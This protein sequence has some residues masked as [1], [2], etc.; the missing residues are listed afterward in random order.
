MGIEFLEEE[1]RKIV[2]HNKNFGMWENKVNDLMNGG[3]L[4]SLKF[5]EI[6][7]KTPIDW[8]T[9]WIA[10]SLAS[11]TLNGN[12]D[13]FEICLN[14]AKKQ[15]IISGYERKN[16]GY[17]ITLADGTKL[18]FLTLVELIPD[19]SN[20][21]K[22]RLQSNE[23]YGHCH[24]DSIHLSKVLEIPNRVVSGYCTCQSKK[25]PYTHSWV[26]VDYQDR[27]WV[28]DFTMNLAMNKD[29]YYKLY[30]PQ[31]TVEI[32]SQTLKD[33]LDLMRKTSMGQKDLR[34]YLFYPNE[35]REVMQEEYKGHKTYET[36]EFPWFLIEK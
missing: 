19:L 28:L 16:K 4:T 21:T 33:D 9:L 27:E 5:F 23:R 35:A 31:N 25:M 30:N 14:K 3:K 18:R 17:E 10:S 29:A 12:C 13:N 7:K 22:K 26:E 6:F 2:K 1:L 34:M 8:N 15:R 32:D 11:F 24:W 36:E 20:D